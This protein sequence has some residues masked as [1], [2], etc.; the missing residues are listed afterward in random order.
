MTSQRKPILRCRVRTALAALALCA[1]PVH[2]ALF[3]VGPD[4]DGACTHHVIQSAVSAAAQSP[5]ADIVQVVQGSWSA[6]RI[7]VLD[8]DSLHLEGGYQSCSQLLRVGVSLLS[9]Q[10]AVPAG[11]VV[12]HYGA[13]ALTLRNLTLSNGNAVL[14]GGIYSEGPATLTLSNV[15]LAGNVAQLGGGLAVIGPATRKAV[16]L[17]GVGFNSNTAS[18]SGGGLFVRNANVNIGGSTP[19]YFLGNIAQGSAAGQ[20]GGGIHAADSLVLIDSLPLPGSTFM[21]GNF[22]QGDGG[23]IL[24]YAS[25]PSGAA[26]Y[27]SNQ[28][29][30]QPL[31][32]N[33]NAAQGRGG[34]VFMHAKSAGQTTSALVVLYNA[35]LRDNDATR[36]GAAWVEAEGGAQAAVARLILR[37]SFPGHDAAPCAAQMRCNRIERSQTFDGSTLHLQSSG[38]GSAAGLRVERGYLLDNLSPAGSLIAGSGEIDIDTSVLAGNVTGGTSLIAAAGRPYHIA[39]ST[40]ADNVIDTGKVVLSVAA[41]P[42]A[43]SL[44]NSIVFQPSNQT[45]SAVLTPATTVRNLLV[46]NTAGL[47]D[48]AANNIQYSADPLFADPGQRDYSLQP[49]SQAIDRWQ[50]D[51]EDAPTSDI[52]GAPRPFTTTP[53]AQT[54]YDFGAYEAGSVYLPVFRDGFEPPQPQN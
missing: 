35:I 47:P 38:S 32:F 2:A 22:A 40:I 36:A 17:F 11:P 8:S 27:A 20:G 26:L 25:E 16:D 54:P 12:S 9:N 31:A 37:Q 5:G 24:L 18:Q 39:N 52:R 21:E 43:S 6:Q 1:G 30:A 49:A 53:G 29:G 50:V 34:A 10:G 48:L 46:G 45:V 44:R 13:G 19:N 42:S 14:G 15:L 4:D 41:A 28:L 7:E 3:T 33:G 51:L 23:A